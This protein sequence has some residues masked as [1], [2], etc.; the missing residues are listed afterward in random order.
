MPSLRPLRVEHLD[1]PLERHVRVRERAEVD[2]ARRAEQFAAKGWPGSSS[3]RSTRVL[4]NM[5]IR[6]SSVGSPRPAI[7]VPIAMSSVADEPRQQ[8]GERGVHHH[9]Q[10]RMLL[11][12]QRAQCRGAGRRRG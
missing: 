1:E 8:H 12:G 4:T 5:P 10:R 2:L 11:A 9:E 7:G 6:S 3:V